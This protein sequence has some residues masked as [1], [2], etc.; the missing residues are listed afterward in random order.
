[1]QKFLSSD[2][3]RYVLK[4][5]ALDMDIIVYPNTGSKRDLCKLIQT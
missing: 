4:P 5:N 3:Y 2:G 1:M